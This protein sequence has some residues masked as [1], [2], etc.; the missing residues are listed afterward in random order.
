MTSNLLSL[1]FALF[2][3]SNGFGQALKFD[4]PILTVKESFGES[5]DT[6]YSIG[7]NLIPTAVTSFPLTVKVEVNENLS[8]AKAGEDYVLLTTSVTFESSSKLNKK[9]HFSVKKD[10]LQEENDEFFRIDAI[11][12]ADPSNKAHSVIRII[13]ASTPSKL[14]IGTPYSPRATFAA[15]FNINLFDVSKSSGAYGAISVTYAAKRSGENQNSN[16][17]SLTKRKFNKDGNLKKYK[18]KTRPRK[19]AFGNK[20]FDSGFFSN[21]LVQRQYYYTDTMKKLNSSIVQQTVLSGPLNSNS[22]DTSIIQLRSFSRSSQTTIS[23]F[24][25]FMRYNGLLAG[26]KKVRLYGGI[27]CQFLSRSFETKTNL[28]LLRSDTISVVGYVKDRPFEGN[29]SVI[30]RNVLNGLFGVNIDFLYSVGSVNVGVNAALGYMTPS[31]FLAASSDFYY[32]FDVSVLERK[33]GI[34]LRFISLGNLPADS[35]FVSVTVAKLVN[36][37]ELGSLLKSGV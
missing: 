5:G 3:F 27:E 24:S 21:G 30:K 9:V 16:L 10:I 26:S 8:L 20:F 33:S 12:Y 18:A 13:N 31:D 7:L 19:G 4:K 32:S 14:T 25:A 15:G 2:I 37:G 23:A 17:V 34:E 36:L 1:V 29:E 11:S 6:D 22:I 28:E 35:P